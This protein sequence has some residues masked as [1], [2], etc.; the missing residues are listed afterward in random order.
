MKKQYWILGIIVLVFWLYSDLGM[1]QRRSD[2]Y[3]RERR[4]GDSGF[5]NQYGLIL[6][7][8]IFTH[9]RGR[10]E[11]E[12][13][14]VERS[15]PPPVQK[16]YVLIGISRWG[17]EYIAFVEN[18][19]YGDTQMCRIGN[20][21]ADMKIKHITLDALELEK[22]AK[23]ITIQIGSDLMGGARDSSLS[24]QDLID[25]TEEAASSTSPAESTEPATT[26]SADTDDILKKLLER[27]KKELE[28]Q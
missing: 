7:R 6:E 5:M 10:R 3:S 20:T 28:Q 8:N 24:V 15:A 11:P 18:T 14:R 26:G 27:R 1:A 9:E 25:R 13:P 21:V 12:T 17:E 2:R 22:D 19:R 16:S 4:G 23:T